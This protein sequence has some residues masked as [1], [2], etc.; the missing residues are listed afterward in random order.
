[1][2][3][4]KFYC[5]F[6]ALAVSSSIDTTARDFARSLLLGWLFSR[7]RMVDTL[8]GCFAEA[9]PDRDADGTY[10]VMIV[11]PLSKDGYPIDIYLRAEGF[12]GPWPWAEE[13]V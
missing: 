3:P 6:E 11:V 5:H 9:S 8:R 12:L 4:I 13:H 2:L 10:I 1:M 7:L